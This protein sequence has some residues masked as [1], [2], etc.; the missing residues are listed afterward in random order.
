MADN[1][2]AYDEN[3]LSAPLS[4]NAAVRFRPGMYL[5]GTDLRA[6]HH[7][8]FELLDLSINA[9]FDGKCH[10]VTIT[11]RPN[12][13]VTIED[14]GEYLPVDIDDRYGQSKL[15]LLFTR[16]SHYDPILGG[17]KVSGG[18]HGVGP[19]VCNAVC[20]WMTVEVARD[21]FIWSQSYQTGLPQV[22]ITCQKQPP[23]A[24]ATGTKIAFKPDFTLFTHFEDDEAIFRAETIRNRSHEL[25]HL[26][27]GLKLIVRDERTSEID[28]QVFYAPRG[29][30]ELIENAI[31]KEAEPLHSLIYAQTN[32]TIRYYDDYSWVN[33]RSMLTKLETPFELWLEF[34]ILFTNRA[35]GTELGYSNTVWTVDGGSHMQGLRAGL[36]K[37]LN[38][39]RPTNSLPFKWNQ[40]PNGLMTAISIRHPN[41][42]FQSQTKIRLLS[43]EVR[44][45]I[46]RVV[47]QTVKSFAAAHP[48]Q[49]QRIIEHCITNR[50]KKSD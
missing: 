26:I 37:A 31:P 8:L 24:G 32:L 49:M 46:K 40:L 21:G 9:A 20:E 42:Q 3:Q 15:E 28:E 27:S 6:L 44:S 19:A 13:A 5:G 34:C 39:H 12:N 7:M 29:L 35:E 38:T 47:S 48:D 17:Y 16:T 22:P 45:P 41:P 18:L 33:R 4:L 36:V 10:L 23:R 14:N 50:A 11:L 2:L 30:Q 25:I 1:P 43:S